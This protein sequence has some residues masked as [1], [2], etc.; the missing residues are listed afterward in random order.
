MGLPMMPFSLL[1]RCW[2]IPKKKNGCPEKS[3]Q[4]FFHVLLLFVI[5]V[6][7]LMKRLINFSAELQ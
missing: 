6:C 3:E 5:W 1:Y 4:P 2:F 7:F